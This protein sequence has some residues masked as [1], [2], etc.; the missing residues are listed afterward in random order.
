MAS[1]QLLFSALTVTTCG[2]MHGQ[3]R[4]C[5]CTSVSY[6]YRRYHF[7]SL[8]RNLLLYVSDRNLPTYVSDRNISLENYNS[9]HACMCAHSFPGIR[10]VSLGFMHVR[11]LFCI[12]CWENVGSVGPLAGCIEGCSHTGCV[13]PRSGGAWL[14]PESLCLSLKLKQLGPAGRLE[15][16]PDPRPP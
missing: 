13:S 15:G 7:S 4:L 16:S 14:V 6:F 1:G 2:S 11:K 9:P 3:G 5:G 10:H 8:M 12:Y